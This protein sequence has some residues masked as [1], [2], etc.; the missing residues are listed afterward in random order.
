MDVISYPTLTSA[1]V[2]TIYKSVE[3]FRDRIVKIIYSDG[4]ENSSFTL[5]PVDGTTVTP[6]TNPA[7]ANGGNLALWKVTGITD[8]QHL[9]TIDGTDNYL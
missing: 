9:F 2:R 7:T 1:P 5:F 6:T 4:F 3:I 8:S